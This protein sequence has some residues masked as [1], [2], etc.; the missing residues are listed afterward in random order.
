[1]TKRH[2]S[3]NG[4]EKL[5][6]RLAIGLVLMFGGRGA[7]ASDATSVE[8]D[9]ILERMAIA[10][11]SLKSM[12]A[13]LEQVKSY[14]QLG[15]TDPAER[16][17][18]HFKRKGAGRHLLRLEIQEP[19]Q[20]I[21]TV[22]EDGS[23]LLYQPKIKQ[24][25]EGKVDRNAGGRSGTSFMSYFLGD[26]SSAK[27]DYEIASLGTQMVGRHHTVRL[28][29]TAKPDGQGY[30]RQI[31]LWVDTELWV[32]VQQELVEPNRSVTKLMFS[33]IHINQEIKDSLFTVKLPP[34][35]ERVRG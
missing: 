19:E 29:L 25:I 32:P 33:G 13:E 1:M 30:Y 8:A 17:Q 12:G 6:V 11:Q 4:L 20:R 7:V 22:R 35:V 24:A 27:K 5:G 15:L 28:R 3:K 21:V 18:V 10:Y 34:D 14:P 16:G 23:Y 2:V 9:E 31:D 26:L